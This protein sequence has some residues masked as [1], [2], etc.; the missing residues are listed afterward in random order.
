MTG[1]TLA[2]SLINFSFVHLGLYFILYIT[3]N[4][5]LRMDGELF[6][7]YKLVYKWWII[8]QTIQYI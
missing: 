3:N 6:E 5:I 4:N 1:S 2:D 7:L 8:D